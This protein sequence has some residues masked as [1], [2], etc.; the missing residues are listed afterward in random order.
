[1]ASSPLGREVQEVVIGAL[2]GIVVALGV[3]YALAWRNL[4]WTSALVPAATGLFATAGLRIV[5]SWSVGWWW[6]GS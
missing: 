5:E 2:L 1:M 6:A 4:R 3:Q